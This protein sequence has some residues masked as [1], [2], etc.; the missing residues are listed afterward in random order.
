MA[1]NLRT[2]PD[3]DTNRPSST[4]DQNSAKASAPPTPK[5]EPQADFTFKMPTKLLGST[6]GKSDTMSSNMLSYKF[7]KE[8]CFYQ[9]SGSAA[10]DRDGDDYLN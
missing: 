2:E 4:R 6:I 1:L 10:V 5:D 8:N 3:V 7:T 9:E